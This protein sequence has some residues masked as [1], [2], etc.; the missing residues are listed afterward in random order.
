MTI[1]D[2]VDIFVRIVWS[3][4]GNF[5][6]YQ[7]IDL[8]NGLIVKERIHDLANILTIRNVKGFRG[9]GHPYSFLW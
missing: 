4:F 8:K 6:V 5:D 7:G 9:V 2:L 3:H 1:G